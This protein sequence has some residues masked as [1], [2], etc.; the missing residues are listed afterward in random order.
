MLRHQIA[1]LRRTAPKPRQ[2]WTGRVMP[3]AMAR[4]LP[5]WLCGHRIVTPGT[6][7][8]LNELSREGLLRVQGDAIGVRSVGRSTDEHSSASPAQVDSNEL[9]GTLIEGKLNR[10][11]TRHY[12][13]LEGL[14]AL[15]AGN[16]ATVK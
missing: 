6:L 5:K 9:A 2:N 10:V 7:L 1:V 12:V 13:E 14:S 15:D 8:G 16:L 3:A 4:P 11:W